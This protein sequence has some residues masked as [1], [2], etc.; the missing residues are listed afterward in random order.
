MD[1]EVAL[2]ELVELAA[3]DRTVAELLDRARPE[4]APGD[5]GAP[6]HGALGLRQAVDPR[7]DHRLDGVG[8]PSDCPPDS[9]SMRTVSSMKSGLP[10]VVAS[11]VSRSSAVSSADSP[12]T[13]ASTS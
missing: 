12:A 13:S 7:G 6:Q 10:S 9:S 2:D 11:T 4:H 1:E 3:L 5:G 8:N